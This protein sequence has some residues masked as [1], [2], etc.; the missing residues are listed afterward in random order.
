M[1]MIEDVENIKFVDENNFVEFKT[2]QSCDDFGWDIFDMAGILE[3]KIDLKDCVFIGQGLDSP[4]G[5]YD[6]QV[7]IKEKDRKY[8]LCFYNY[9]QTYYLLLKKICSKTRVRNNQ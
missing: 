1:I 5:K 9:P 6:F 8:N 2:P 3:E 4:I 7:E